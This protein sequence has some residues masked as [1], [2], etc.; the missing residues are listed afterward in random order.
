[1]APARVGEREAHGPLEV[2]GYP[3]AGAFEPGITPPRPTSPEAPLNP[4]LERPP[5]GLRTRNAVSA[6]T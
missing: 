4:P 3:A 2:P 6:E 1:M 5:P